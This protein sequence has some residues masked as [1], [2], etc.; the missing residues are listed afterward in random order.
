[1]KIGIKDIANIVDEGKAQGIDVRVR[2]LIYVYSLSGFKDHEVIYKALFGEGYTDEQ[3]QE[4]KNSEKIKFIK[5]KV[6][7]ICPKNNI[8]NKIY[9]DITFEENK[10]ALIKYLDEIQQMADQGEIK[11]IDAYKLQTAI[12]FKLEEKFDM[13]DKKEE[14]KIIVNT[15]YN[16]ICEWTRK[17]CF[18][19]TKEYAMKNWGLIEDPNKINR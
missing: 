17:E 19:Q 12:R 16:H 13:S 5:E 3:I 1:M 2:D 18:L 7:K 10:D 15:K 6:E 14:Q 9:K 4:Y 11:M 8:N